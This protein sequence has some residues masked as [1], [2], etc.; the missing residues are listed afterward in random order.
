MTTDINNEKYL[1]YLKYK[2][3]YLKLK[4]M[5]GGDISNDLY[6]NFLYILDD[7]K[8]K[9]LDMKDI[10]SDFCLPSKGENNEDVKI[11]KKLFKL[12]DNYSLFGTLAK[13]IKKL[14]E[15]QTK[16]DEYKQ[17]KNDFKISSVKYLGRT[18][19]LPDYSNIKSIKITDMIFNYF[20]TKE[21]YSEKFLI[22]INNLFNSKSKP[23]IRN[24]IVPE[25]L[26][27]KKFKNEK[28]KSDYPIYFMFD[29]DYE[30][31]VQKIN[32][33]FNDIDSVMKQNEINTD[34]FEM[35]VQ[36]LF[37]KI[38]NKIVESEKVEYEIFE[39]NFIVP[40]SIIVNSDQKKNLER[41]V[42]KFLNNTKYINNII[43]ENND[44]RYIFELIN[45]IVQLLN[46]INKLK[47]IINIAIFI[48]ES[49]LNEI[50]K[51]NDKNN[52]TDEEIEKI[53]EYLNFEN[54]NDDKFKKI[55]ENVKEG[56]IV[57]IKKF[58]SKLQNINDYYKLFK[59]AYDRLSKFYEF[60]IENKYLDENSNLNDKLINDLNKLNY[61]I[62]NIGKKNTQ[63]KKKT[64]KIYNIYD[65][66]NGYNS[67]L[68]K[69]LDKM[70]N[71]TN[72]NEKKSDLNAYESYLVKYN[73]R[74]IGSIKNIKNLLSEFLWF[75]GN[76]ERKKYVISITNESKFD[77]YKKEL[78]RVIEAEKRNIENKLIG[79]EMLNDINNLNIN[80]TKLEEKKKI[81]END[82]KKIESKIDSNKFGRNADT[83]FQFLSELKKN[84]ID[85][86]EKLNY[87]NK[88]LDAIQSQIRRKKNE[89]DSKFKIDKIKYRPN[90][91]FNDIDPYYYDTI[92]FKLY[93]YKLSDTKYKE[94]SD[95]IKEKMKK[96]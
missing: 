16:Y 23:I 3:K 82:I 7:I 27:N 51:N 73:L 36:K 10:I 15:N 45:Q 35:D 41:T 94:L 31:I 28:G 62:K 42:S 66:N 57:V 87:V 58:K 85:E 77:Y 68:K 30:N 86:N 44:F 24:N 69:I 1:K 40:K 37:N 25:D 67:I 61:D 2:F 63:A 78:E 6:K 65:L 26:Y 93:Y 90:T 91:F 43:D 49:Q 64:L 12:N 18:H 11:F 32:N 52:F 56:L 34:T 54:I 29:K 46:F 13:I 89:Y 22:S 21:Y 71:N 5:Y 80:R 84:K 81:I 47:D 55:N 75:V 96:N 88:E 17:E 95:Q 9:N 14:D 76:D 79:E 48:F 8:Q 72:K 53:K 70:L 39:N 33:I 59:K 60:F 74:P 92:R 50:M 20:K 83:W 4:N 19:K 38:I